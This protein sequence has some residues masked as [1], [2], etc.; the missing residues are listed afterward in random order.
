MDLLFFWHSLTTRAQQP[1]YQIENRLVPRAPLVHRILM[2]Q[3][4]VC[5][6]TY[7]QNL[8]FMAKT[9]KSWGGLNQSLIALRFR[10]AESQQNVS[11][12]GERKQSEPKTQKPEEPWK[13]LLSYRLGAQ[14]LIEFANMGMCAVKWPLK[15]AVSQTKLLNSNRLSVKWRQDD[16]DLL[17][18]FPVCR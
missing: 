3:I 12:L 1:S 5:C 6:S 7:F 16:G 8:S 2:Q 4:I 18:S 10:C 9:Q 11:R 14:L 13:S 17:E 15:T